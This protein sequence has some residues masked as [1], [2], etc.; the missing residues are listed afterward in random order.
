VENHTFFVIHN[1][2]FI[3]LRHPKLATRK[4]LSSA[5]IPMPF[6]LCPMLFGPDT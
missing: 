3:K 2:F 1:F 4:L 5:S 6:A